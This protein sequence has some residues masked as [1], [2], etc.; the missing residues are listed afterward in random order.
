MSNMFVMRLHLFSTRLYKMSMYYVFRRERPCA[1]HVS[2]AIVCAS[3]IL[4]LSTVVR[5]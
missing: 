3:V 4:K 2:G 5:L 1:K